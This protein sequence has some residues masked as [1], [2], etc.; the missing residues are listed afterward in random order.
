MD[1][2][3]RCAPEVNLDEA[4]TIL[5]LNLNNLVRHMM[6]ALK[7][8]ATIKVYQK[9]NVE[10]EEDEEGNLWPEAE[11]LMNAKPNDFAT[12]EAWDALCQYWSTPSFRKKSLRGK[13]NRLAG[14][15]NVYHCS[16]SRSLASTRQ[17]LKIRDGVDPGQIGAWHHQHKMQ[18]GTN[19]QLCSNKA[20]NLW[21][22]YDNT[23]T[24]K[25]GENWQAEHLDIDHAVVHDLTGVPHG[26]FAMGDGV[27]GP[28][29]ADSIKSRKRS[30]PNSQVS[31]ASSSRTML[32]QMESNP[33]RRAGIERV[34]EAL[35]EK[36]NLDFNALMRPESEPNVEWCDGVERVLRAMAEIIPVDI[37]ALLHPRCQAQST[38]TSVG[39]S[40]AP[41][42]RRESGS[43]GH[44]NDGSDTYEDDEFSA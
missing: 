9:E 27:I 2:D 8:E 3:Q 15:D 23:M 30:R 33:H 6:C 41:V 7:K 5:D 40:R 32:G 42:Q 26:T 25:C 43:T 34:L 18:Q 21:E 14:G 38:S 19:S 13:E 22:R 12:R 1:G 24:E 16:G 20:A 39:A 17:F 10:E 11:E 4:D 36:I 31:G 37:S 44:M 35:A 29:E 28:S